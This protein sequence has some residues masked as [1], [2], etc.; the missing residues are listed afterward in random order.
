QQQR[1]AAEA[2]AALEE[3]FVHRVYS[4]MAPALACADEG[5][6]GGC[7]NRRGPPA[8]VR[9]LLRD[10]PPGCL[11]ADLGCG[12]SAAA[13]S[14]LAAARGHLAVGADICLDLLLAANDDWHRRRSRGRQ[15]RQPLLV[16]A[17]VLRCPLRSAAFDAVTCVSVVHHLASRDRR[18]RLLA[19]AARLLRPGG[20]LLVTAW[21]FEQPGR[22]ARSFN[23]QDLL[24]PWGAPEPPQTPALPPPPKPPPRPAWQRRLSSLPLLAGFFGGS[25]NGGGSGDCQA[26]SSDCESDSSDCEFRIREFPASS[27][28][29]R[30]TAGDCL[31]DGAC[32]AAGAPASEGRRLRYYHVF[33][34]G[35]LADCARGLGLDC[36]REWHEQGNWCLSARRMP[37]SY[38]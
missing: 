14:R 2:E 36:L 5:G 24:V 12:H 3:R 18:R 11:L 33:R 23:C 15:R 26:D 30:H 38:Y 22:P 28:P 17:D 37:P 13:L 27:C 34:Q 16:Q 9:D 1:P 4:C 19:E 20:R 25:R 21:A 32:G 8:C 10:L 29:R 35:E 7:A 31:C 6:S